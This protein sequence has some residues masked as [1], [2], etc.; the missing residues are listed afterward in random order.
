MQAVLAKLGGDESGRIVSQ[1]EV[2]RRK[3]NRLRERRAGGGAG[4]REGRGVGLIPK[5]MRKK[6]S[7]LNGGQRKRRSLFSLLILKIKEEVGER[8]NGLRGV[9]GGREGVY[10]KEDNIT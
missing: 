1:R 5:F 8:E 4:G 6:R 3:I 10:I 9:G 2:G 7:A